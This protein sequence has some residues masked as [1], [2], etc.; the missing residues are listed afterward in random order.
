MKPSKPIGSGTSSSRRLPR[1]IDSR[2]QL[3]E[4]QRAMA[5]ALFRPLTPQWRM[6]KAWVDGGSMRE[7]AAEFIKPNDR[8]SAFERLEI[9]SRQYW[10]RVLDCLYDDYPGLRAVVGERRFMKLAIA[11]LA[12]YPS[13]SYNLRDLG[14]RL[15]LFLQHEPHWVAPREELALDMVRFEWAQVMAFD[16]PSKPPI[17]PDDVLDTPPDRLRLGLQPYLSLLALRYAVDNFLIAV[18]QREADSLRGE[19][20]NAV[21][22]GPKA[23]KRRRSPRLP[24]REP[25]H[26]AVHR[27][28]NMLYYKRLEPEAFAILSAL[29]RGATVEDACVAAVEA[30][31]RADCDWPAQIK[32]WFDTWSAL[33]WFC[34]HTAAAT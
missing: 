33:G 1:K 29:A 5:S 20:S 9:Y 3:R 22:A 17:S 15:E 34:H 24:D 8:L 14:N 25:I 18:K 10:F 7:L 31:D 4:L 32:A 2:A 13:E 28:N 11:Y 12:R 19:A 21:A 26:L 6:Q 27:L 16:G 30:S 23:T